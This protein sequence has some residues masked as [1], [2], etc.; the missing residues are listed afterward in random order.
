MALLQRVLS[1]LLE[2]CSISQENLLLT[3][4]PICISLIMN[5]VKCSFVFYILLYY[6]CKIFLSFSILVTLLYQCILSDIIAN[7]SST[8]YLIVLLIF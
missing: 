8:F 4:G 5:E 3:M 1:K 7:I 6:F 2:F